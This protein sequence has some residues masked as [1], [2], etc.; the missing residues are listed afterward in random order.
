MLSLLAAAPVAT[1]PLPRRRETAA[2]IL[3]KRSRRAS[4]PLPPA[5]TASGDPLPACEILALGSISVYASSPILA[6]RTTRKVVIDGS[7]HFDPGSDRALVRGNRAGVPSLRAGGLLGLAGGP[8][9][10]CAAGLRTRP[11]RGDHQGKTERRDHPADGERGNYRTLHHLRG[12]LRLRRLAP[13]EGAADSRAGLERSSQPRPGPK[14]SSLRLLAATPMDRR[15][16]NDKR[17]GTN[18]RTRGSSARYPGQGAQ[19]ELLNQRL[20]AATSRSARR[21]RDVPAFDRLQ[22]STPAQLKRPNP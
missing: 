7:G 2:P 18:K 4:R 8:R 10:R 1:S 22:A 14:R 3:P 9:I 15:Q 19:R 5:G 20:E 6:R 13:R 17:P 12:H 16:T 21:F 11:D